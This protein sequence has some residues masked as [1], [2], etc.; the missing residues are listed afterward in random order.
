MVFF[1]GNMNRNERHLSPQLIIK[2]G[3]QGSETGKSMRITPPPGKGMPCLCSVQGASLTQAYKEKGE[4]K[5]GRKR[6]STQL[7]WRAC[8]ARST[9]GEM[10]CVL[11]RKKAQSGRGDCLQY[12]CV[13]S[14]W[15]D[16]ASLGRAR[17]WSRG[18]NWLARH[19]VNFHGCITPRR[20]D[21]PRGRTEKI[22]P[23]EKKKKTCA[24]EDWDTPSIQNVV[25]TN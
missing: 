16:F 7:P 18:K 23:K 3:G 1:S 6:E 12:P 9:G 2:E 17:Y 21:N 20:H 10:A 15:P 5:K 19:S 14:A 11:S 4:G 24:K 13:G 22:V 25:C 8:T